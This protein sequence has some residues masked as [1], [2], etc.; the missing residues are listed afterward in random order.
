[1]DTDGIERVDVEALGGA[2][3]LTLNDL[4]GTA[5]QE[6]R[7][8]LEAVKGGGAADDKIDRVI[9]NGTDAADFVSVCSRVRAT[10]SYSGRRS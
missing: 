5:V 10:C 4:T 3:T 7:L 6:L 9:L 1:M 2:D 8:D